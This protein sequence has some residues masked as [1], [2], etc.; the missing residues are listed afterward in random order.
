MTSLTRRVARRVAQR[1]VHALWHRLEQAGEIVPGTAAG[2]RFGRLG[3]GSSIGFPSA[4]VMNPHAIAVGE[5]TLV[6]RY[7]TLSVGYGPGDPSARPGT[8][9]IG[10]RCVVGA[11]CTITA[12]GSI[13]IA[14][15][16]WFGQDVFVSDASHGY[17]DPIEP[18]G[19]QFGEHRPVE[20]GAGSWIGHG[21][22][23]LPGA[24]IGR[25]VVVAAGSVV[26]GEVPDHC[27]VAGVPARVVRRIDVAGDPAADP[28]AD[29][30]A[31][32]GGAA[33][34]MEA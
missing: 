9:V 10:D 4:T 29:L 33:G 17:T 34:R 1:A 2:D 24:R 23:I 32:A 6:G 30:A 21:A 18:I 13:R 28:A 3:R 14:D 15:D 25:H 20:I 31:L 22:V 19:R 16:V 8:L 27:V 7:V 12:H 11:R 5:D 26:R